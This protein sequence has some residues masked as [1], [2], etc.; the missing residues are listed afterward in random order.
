M[1]TQSSP[2][3]HDPYASLRI[4]DFRLFVSARFFLTVATQMQGVIV[5]W[6][7]YQITGD[8]LALGMV[9]L[10]EALP[11]MTV[12]LYAG[13]LADIISRKKIILIA[14]SGFLA[15]SILLL[16]FT[17]HL[18]SVLDTLGAL[19]IY[20]IICLTGVARG[21]AGP[22]FSAFLA[23]LVSR[24]LYS[25]AA[26]W[27]TT[28]WQTAAVSGPAIGGL[29]YGYFGIQTAYGVVAAL[30]VVS[31]LC[32][33]G[34]AARPLTLSEKK[35]TLRERLASGVRFVFGNQV[36]L[37]ALSLDLFAV[38]FGGAVA[39]LPIFAD[40]ILHVG[41]QGLGLLRAAPALGAVLMGLF[42]AHRP[43]MEGAGRYL[44]L[45][46]AGFGLCMI[47]FALSTS[48]YFSLAVLALSGALDAVSVVIRSTIMQLLTPDDMRGR[49]SAV[50]SVFIGSSNEIGSFESG[51]AAR[52]LGLVPSVV[53]GGSM[54][55][56]VVGVTAKIAPR[57]RQLDLRE[58]AKGV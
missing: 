45:C 12:I 21:F 27:N 48:F 25:G 16:L 44:L 17:L 13:H 52:L 53:F 39:L 5:G 51:V 4:K 28:V 22:S 15:C 57:L 3:R 58:I 23:Q 37:G 6:Q 10:A 33:T 8:P 14:L 9:G 41:P 55:L 11:F 29:L 36:F 2:P 46:V 26:A 24:D 34:I 20:G 56:L 30:I 43:P 7:I 49:V 40:E 19:P 35:E 50:N 31:L 32:I 1:S 18:S 38:F 42:L 54:T 47:A